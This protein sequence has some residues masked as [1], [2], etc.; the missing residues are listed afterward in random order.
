MIRLLP[1]VVVAVLAGCAAP[2]PSMTAAEG[3]AMV[4]S[5]MPASVADKDGWA[6]DIYS[7]VAVLEIPVTA[8]NICAILSVTEQESGFRVDPV[9]PNL[10]SLAWAEIERQREKIGIPKLVLDAALSLQSSNG[11][12][13]RERLNA[14]RTERELSDTFEDM[15]G[16]V[17]L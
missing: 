14:A 6:A 4:A 7:A 16:R 10:S 8:D 3:R 11:R 2:R 5:Y 1:F 17:P 12:S 9:I 15:I 13:Y